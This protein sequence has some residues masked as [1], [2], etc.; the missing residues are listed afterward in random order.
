MHIHT[1]HSTT[2]FP[3]NAPPYPNWHIFV[4]T[5]VTVTFEVTYTSPDDAAGNFV[6]SYL[7]SSMHLQQLQQQQQL[8][9]PTTSKQQKHTQ[10]PRLDGSGDAGGGSSVAAASISGVCRQPKR[11]ASSTGRPA[12]TTMD[13]IGGGGDGGGGV[14][15][16]DDQQMLLNIEQNIVN[17]ERSFGQTDALTECE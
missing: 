4:H 1:E 13:D 17:L 7:N 11:T 3:H 2:H 5:Q 10:Y 16:D 15:D 6:P 14:D 12:T 9:Q 8:Q